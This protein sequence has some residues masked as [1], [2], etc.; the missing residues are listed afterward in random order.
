MIYYGDD[1]MDALARDIQTLVEPLL[2]EHGLELVD[3]ETSRQGKKLWLRI[4]VDHPEGGINVEECAQI[5]R[6]LGTILDV[7]DLIEE[8]YIL[9]V[10]SPGV[11][12][13]IR[14]IKDFQRFQGNPIRVLTKEKIKGQ[15]RFRGLLISVDDDGIDLAVQG[16]DE[17]K[18]H[19]PH[20]L[21]ARANLEHK[22]DSDNKKENHHG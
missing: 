6:E 7:E 4:F 16:A 13:R 5:N 19:I 11:D 3:M 1:L 22:P 12:R 2:M 10:S 20:E 9:E 17:D 14:K 18:V 15:K 21:I 8:S